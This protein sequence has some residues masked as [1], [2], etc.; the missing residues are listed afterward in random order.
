MT[1]QRVVITG[2][3]VVSALG[4]NVL[5]FNRSLQSGS[6]GIGQLKTL[7]CDSISARIGA[8]VNGL[9]LDSHFDRSQLPILDRTSKFAIY[10]AR[11]AVKESGLSTDGELGPRTAVIIGTGAGCATSIEDSY[12]TYYANRS[13][14]AHPLTVPKIMINAP[15]GHISMDLGITGPSFAISAACASSANALVLATQ[16][17]R[18]GMID[19]VIVGG[20]EACLTT[21][22]FKI[23]EAM[24][25]LAP[26]T[27]RPFSNARM[28]LVLGEGAA[29]FVLERLDLAR[30]RSAQIFGE[31]IGVAM[32]SDAHHILNPLQDRQADAIRA[33][34]HD[35]GMDGEQVGY[36]NAHGT[37]TAV[38]DATETRAIKDAFGSHARSLKVSSTKSMHGHTLGCAGALEL[39]ATAIGLENGF[40]PPTMN[41]S[42]PD[43]D[44]DLN[45]V[46][47]EAQPLQTKAALSNSF[48]FGGHNA[49]IALRA[50]Q[51]V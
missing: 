19:T 12:E 51:Y 3:G 13:R 7:S 4:N 32:N 31:V 35:A 18:S 39:L 46:T 41:F 29:V 2:R 5:D 50:A 40:A 28:G 45:Y 23:W 24:R 34:L 14:R 30:K 42:E 33:C 15:A 43:P 11:Q 17:I 47:N 10:A 9:D 38:N 49:V 26:D 6:V 20:A 16:M 25:V 1:L 48:A 27:C 22:C 8:Q 21:G 36:V 44:C 37:A